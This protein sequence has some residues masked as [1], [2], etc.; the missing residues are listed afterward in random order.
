[1][2]RYLRLLTYVAELTHFKKI[3][4]TFKRF[5]TPFGHLLAT[6]YTVMFF[7]IVVGML[8]Y[9]GKINTESVVYTQIEAPYMY[10]LMNFNDFYAS[11]MTLFHVIVINN[12]NNTTEMYCIVMGNNLPR[13]YFMSYWILAVL[14]S[15]NLVISFVLEIYSAVGEEVDERVAK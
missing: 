14:C 15:F 5:S 3:V 10:Y 7:Y 8:L 2:L 9:S 11:M 4:E 12:W 6:M 13:I 1:M